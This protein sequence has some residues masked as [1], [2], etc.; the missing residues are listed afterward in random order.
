M[1]FKKLSKM[2]VLLAVIVALPGCNLVRDK[3]CGGKDQN[4]CSSSLSDK[5]NEITGN[6]N[7]NKC[8][9]SSCDMSCSAALEHEGERLQSLIPSC[10][11]TGMQILERKSS[12]DS[13]GFFQKVSEVLELPNGFEFVFNES[14][15]FSHEL[16][17][18]VNF[19]RNCCSD[20]SFGLEFEP[21]MGPTHLKIYGSEKVKSQ[22]ESLIQEFNIK[23]SSID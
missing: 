21:N 17:D 22:I 9:K 7:C 5:E 4:S 1:N 11:L 23:K 8:G 12:I 14:S 6:G 19:E 10:N 18:F 2:V 3:C 20:F 13:T 16:L 15:E